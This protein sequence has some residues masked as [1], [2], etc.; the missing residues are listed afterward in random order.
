MQA[1]DILCIGSVLWDIIGRSP[2][3]M[4][5]GSDV[6]G[7]ITR[8]PG[9]VAMNIAMTLRRF[10]LT[11]ALLS[12]IG[13]DPEGDE[14]VAAC[15]RMGLDTAQLYRSEDLPTDR[16]M[17]V[18]GANGLIAAIADAHSLEAAG[19]KILRPLADGRL[20]SEAAPYAGLI[21]LDGNLTEALLADIAS[22]PLFAAADLRIAPASPGKAERLSPLLS[23]PRAT[24][25]L[26]LEEAGILCRA[27]FEGAEAAALALL[28]RGAERV[29]VT[30]GGRACA[31]GRR[32]LG[33][34]TGTPPAVLVTRVTGAGDTFMAAHI[35]A[36][37]RGDPREAALTAALRA[38]ADYISG[39]IGS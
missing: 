20:G 6:P 39:E 5:V 2:T 37:R 21:A 36:E 8:L 22:S 31:D 30:D 1:P 13:R 11:P 9:G 10:G 4:R 32:G 33:V 35:V 12:A 28:E 38:A 29:L 19:D 26:N 3:A 16:Y 15:A 18:E 27:R 34:L 23:H 25:Y 7:R 14:L 24:L 17:A